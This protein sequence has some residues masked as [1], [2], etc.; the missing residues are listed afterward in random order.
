MRNH[1]TRRLTLEEPE[2]EEKPEDVSEEFDL[3]L[4]MEPDTELAEKSSAPAKVTQDKTEVFDLDMDLDSEAPVKASF[5]GAKD[6]KQ[7]K[8]TEDKTEVFDLDLDLDEDASETS[9]HGKSGVK[10][11]KPAANTDVFDLDLEEDSAES[12]SPIEFDDDEKPAN[13]AEIF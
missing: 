6:K 8:I 4:E 12:K 1:R 9:D 3:N 10:A 13:S 5:G 11:S 7:T 2:A